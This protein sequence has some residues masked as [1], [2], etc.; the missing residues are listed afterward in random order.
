MIH[1]DLEYARSLI[2]RRDTQEQTDSVAESEESWDLLSNESGTED[3]ETSRKTT[4]HFLDFP[5]SLGA[6]GRSGHDLG[7]ETSTSARSSVSHDDIYD[8]NDDDDDD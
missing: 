8:S 6:Q 7:G 4:S 2:K 5:G 3:A 1:R